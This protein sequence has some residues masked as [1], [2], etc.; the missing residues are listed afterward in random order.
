MNTPKARAATGAVIIAVDRAT[1]HRAMAVLIVAPTLDPTAR[2]IQVDQ[3][4]DMAHRDRAMIAHRAIDHRK[5]EAIH[6]TT[7]AIVTAAAA[8]ITT[9]MTRA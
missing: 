7:A 2:A 1:A 4:R 3:I 5:A 8:V 9:A 6:P